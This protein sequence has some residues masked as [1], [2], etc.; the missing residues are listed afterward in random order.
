MGE[1]HQNEAI[2]CSSLQ[3]I[4]TV[5]VP[6]QNICYSHLRADHF[7]QDYECYVSPR[8]VLVMKDGIVHKIPINRPFMRS[9]D[10]ST[11]EHMYGGKQCSQSKLR[12]LNLKA[13]F[14]LALDS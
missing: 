11:D 13:I 7:L 1:A 9:Y 12:K 8:K 2:H 5:W 10:L 3:S 14:S 6:Q 4:K